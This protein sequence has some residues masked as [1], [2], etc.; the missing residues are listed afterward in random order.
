[1]DLF[2]FATPFQ[3]GS[4]IQDT[5]STMWVERY[6]NNGEFQI[7]A[8]VSSGLRETLPVGSFISHIDT[9]EIMVVENHEINDSDEANTDIVVTGRSL[10]TFLEQ[11]VVGSN[12]T[13]PAISGETLPEYALAQNFSWHQAVKLINDHIYA[14]SLVDSNDALSSIQAITD[15][16]P[17]GGGNYRPIKRGEVYQRLLEILEISDI[18][19]K[20]IRPGTWSPFAPAALKTAIVV[21]RGEDRTKDVGFSYSSGEIARAD[22][23]WSNKRLKTSALVSGK[24]LETIVHGGATGYNRRVMYVDASDLDNAYSVA[25]TGSERTTILANM[26]TRGQQALSAKNAVSIAKAEIT[27]NATRYLYRRDFNIGDIV[28][29]EGNYDSSTSMRVVEYVEIEDRTGET[30]YPTLAGL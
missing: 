21:H 9:T 8:P 4:L 16:L 10:E 29:V 23:L 25:P 13:W 11:R 5:T 7:V 19:I 6:R 22:Y 2:K 3:T 18:G 27:K 14:P 1:M 17:T 24:W 26:Q 12:R 15:I 20:T 28:A 30:N